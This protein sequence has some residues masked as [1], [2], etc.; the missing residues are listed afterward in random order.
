MERAGQR[1]AG[2]A[3]VS[4]TSGRDWSPGGGGSSGAGAGPGSE[5]DRFSGGG[6]GGGHKHQVVGLW[7]RICRRRRSCSALA[8][9]M[10]FCSFFGGEVFQNH[11]EPGTT[12]DLLEDSGG[13][14][15]Y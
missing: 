15:A 5:W 13:G 7:P 1:E 11:F 6:A 8:G 2:P 14:D 4:R 9:A 12:C 3:R 10:S